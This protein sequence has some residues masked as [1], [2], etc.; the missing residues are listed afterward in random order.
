MYKVLLSPVVFLVFVSAVVQAESFVSPDKT[1]K[2]DITC[3][4]NRT[5]C[6]VLYETAAG[7]GEIK[8]FADQKDRVHIRWV[9]NTALVTLGLGTYSGASFLVDNKKGLSG[10]YQDVLAVDE[11]SLCVAI[12]KTA[13]TIEFV[14][15]RGIGKSVNVGQFEPPPMQTASFLTIADNPQLRNNIF[16]VEY[17][18]RAGVDRVAS[19]PSG[20]VE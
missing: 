10:P 13:D 14:S 17:I 16:S 4:E 11:H 20:C 5:H 3:Q 9:G 18:D 1:V 8:D 12:M 15:P 6:Q 19:V 2:V 7:S